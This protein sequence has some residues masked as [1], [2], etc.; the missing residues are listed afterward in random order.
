MQVSQVKSSLGFLMLFIVVERFLE[1]LYPLASVLWSLLMVMK[2]CSEE[3][4]RCLFNCDSCS[5]NV[6][7][8]VQNQTFGKMFQT[9]DL[10][11]FLYMVAFQTSEYI[12]QTSD[13]LCLICEP[14]DSI[15]RLASAP[16]RLNLCMLLFLCLCHCSSDS[17]DLQ[18]LDTFFESC[19]CLFDDVTLTIACE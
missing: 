12:N 2:S 1:Y 7:S 16:R 17:I 9:S 5:L 13:I 3:E 8:R 18:L 11:I 4:R 6:N 19:S 15:R 14:E 10:Y